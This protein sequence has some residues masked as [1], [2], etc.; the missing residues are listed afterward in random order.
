MKCFLCPLLFFDIGEY[1][2]HLKDE[3]RKKGK[4]NEFPCVCGRQ[5]LKYD[6]FRAHLRKTQCMSAVPDNSG[7]MSSEHVNEIIECTELSTETSCNIVVNVNHNP[8]TI[9]T[10]VIEID[11][12]V[13]KRSVGE[14]FESIHKSI[15]DLNMTQKATDGVYDILYEIVE[16]S[17]RILQD[18][19]Q[20]PANSQ[21]F[22]IL[23][24]CKNSIRLNLHDYSTKAKRK[25]ELQKSEL[26]VAP[27]EKALGGNLQMKTCKKIGCKIPQ[28]LQ[29]KLYYVPIKETLEK[30]FANEA[31]KNMYVRYNSVEKHRCEEGKYIDFCC[32]RQ[33]KKNGLFRND[34]MALQLQIFIDGFEPCDG[35]KSKTNLHSQ[36][37][38]YF[39][40]RNVP[41]KF[42][43]CLENIHLVA[44]CNAND[45][46]TKQTD[47][48]DLWEFIVRD[49]RAIETEGI[50]TGENRLL[51][52]S[53]NI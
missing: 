4:I 40:I 44:I 18:E 33:Y 10:N 28:Q 49:V 5:Y 3:E 13:D 6:S 9:A 31:F 21:N 46:K 38:V 36:E 1:I 29:S 42:N 37:A 48:N 8:P 12:G 17:Y 24:A 22:E 47:Y 30:L 11:A 35:L 52:G 32:G 53:I 45:L 41:P 23:E 26:Y 34:P 25:K 43:R 27:Q 16:K 39:T 14:H 50:Q 20:F 19:L 51:R 2:N 7:P 15:C